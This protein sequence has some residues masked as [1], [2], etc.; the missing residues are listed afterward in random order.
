MKLLQKF[1]LHILIIFHL[2]GYIGISFIHKEVFA[3]LTMMN[4]LLSALLLVVCHKGDSKGITRVFLFSYI[5]GYSI[6]LLGIKTGFPFGNYYYGHSLGPRLFD[7]PLV[8]GV[9]WF[10]MVM[11]GGYLAKRVVQNKVARII[12]AALFMVIVDFL[13]ESIAPQLNYWYWKD[14]IVPFANFAGWFVVAII[15]QIVFFTFMSNSTNKLGI[16]YIIVVTV[17]FG[18]LNLTL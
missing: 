7:V 3:N 9:N 1:A 2:I 4:L 15:M 12:L 13:I 18:M 5:L 10:L 16:P 11:G 8:I 14:D 17:F 6:E